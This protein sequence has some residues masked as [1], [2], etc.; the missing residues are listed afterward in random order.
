[1]FTITI[2]LTCSGNPDKAMAALDAVDAF[3]DGGDLQEAVNADG[4][5]EDNED[6]EGVAF[7]VTNADAKITG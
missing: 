6:G 3:L 4:E 1:M 2:T 7:K 5:N